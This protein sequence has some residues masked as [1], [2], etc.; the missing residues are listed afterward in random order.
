M[1]KLKTVNPDTLLGHAMIH[2]LHAYWPLAVIVGSM[3]L[4]EQVWRQSRP[5][6]R[7]YR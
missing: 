1:H 2:W 7:R 6:R 5:S 3:M 4:I